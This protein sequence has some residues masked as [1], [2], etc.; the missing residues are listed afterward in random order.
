MYKL[1][2]A[3]SSAMLY[4]ERNER[5]NELLYHPKDMNI[6]DTRVDS[7]NPITVHIFRRLINYLQFVCSSIYE[8]TLFNTA[9]FCNFTCRRNNNKYKYPTNY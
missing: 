2:Y 6:L 5:L 9:I 3:S 4:I 8:S 7:R 1:G